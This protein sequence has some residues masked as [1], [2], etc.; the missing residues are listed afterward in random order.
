MKKKLL[1]LLVAVCV[2][3]TLAL[4]ACGEAP[5]ISFVAPTK[6]HYEVGETLDL[7]G[8]KLVTYNADGTQDAQ[9]VTTAMLDQSTLPNFAQ[10]GE[11]TV[12]GSVENFDFSFKVTVHSVD[13]TVAFVSQQ[14]RPTC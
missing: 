1:L 4:A 13:P 6:L 7:T 8:A 14:Q 3:S 2:L 10:S 12:K 11:Y 5:S 9:D